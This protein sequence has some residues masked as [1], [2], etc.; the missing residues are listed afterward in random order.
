MIKAARA[1]CKMGARIVVIKRGEYGVLL[2]FE[3]NFAFM[4]AYPVENVFDPTG[5][6][7]TF[8]GGFLAHLSGQEK[9]DLSALKKAMVMGTVMS[10]FVIE[11]FS[12]DR[13]MELNGAE[14]EQ[15]RDHLIKMLAMG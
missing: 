3:D 2:S 13:V 5:A 4:P 1:A 15:R 9:I 6:G 8:A 7:D 11:K 10:S 12:F 14:I